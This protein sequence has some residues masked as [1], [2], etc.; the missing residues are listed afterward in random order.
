MSLEQWIALYER[1]EEEATRVLGEV[2]DS[3]PQLYFACVNWY[4]EQGVLP[5]ESGQLAPEMKGT[6]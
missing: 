6:P 2:Y 1:D 3:D 4:V 5:S